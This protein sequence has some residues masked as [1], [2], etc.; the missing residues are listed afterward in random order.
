MIDKHQLCTKFNLLKPDIL[1][2]LGKA[3]VNQKN[4]KK[5]IQKEFEAGKTVWVKQCGK[6]N[7]RKEGI[8]QRTGQVLYIVEEDGKEFCRHA[9]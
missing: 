7:N 2:H 3:W 9:D 6:M 5:S 4:I 1:G 8:V